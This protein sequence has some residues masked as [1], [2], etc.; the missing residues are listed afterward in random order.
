M[1]DACV[2]NNTARALPELYAGLPADWREGEW[3][4]LEEAH[5]ETKR[6]TRLAK[7][8][9]LAHKSDSRARYVV[10]SDEASQAAGPDAENRQRRQD[11]SA[12]KSEPLEA[13]D[14]DVDDDGTASLRARVGA[15]SMCQAAASVS[16]DSSRN[17]F[18]QVRSVLHAARVHFSVP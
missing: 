12:V 8:K 10:E 18:A 3:R 14:I 5:G 4:E 7:A 6:G 11:L 17:L 2:N 13:V 9:Q 16:S 15:G 1:H